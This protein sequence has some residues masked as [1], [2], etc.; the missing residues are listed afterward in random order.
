LSTRQLTSERIG[1]TIVVPRDQLRR[2]Q[3]PVV[4]RPRKR[5]P[6]WRLPVDI[7]AP[8]LLYIVVRVRPEQGEPLK[9]RLLLLLKTNQHHLI[10]GTVARSIGHIQD[11]PDL[12]QILLMWRQ[13]TMPAEHERAATLQALR[14]D[15][16]DLLDWETAQSFEGPAFLS[17]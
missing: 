1:Q 16:A 17:T 5:A 2:F 9:Q 12:I 4:G 11:Q 10:A 15:F 7:N 6:K 14:A 3:R 13:Q 8:Y